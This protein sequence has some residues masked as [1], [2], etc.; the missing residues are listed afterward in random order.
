MEPM[1]FVSWEAL[2]PNQQR[3]LTSAMELQNLASVRM[4]WQAN[5]DRVFNDGVNNRG[6]AYAEALIPAGVELIRMG[7][8]GVVTKDPTFR[9][10]AEDEA[11]VVIQDLNNWWRYRIIP[12]L[13]DPLDRGLAP[14]GLIVDGWWQSKYSLT[15]INQDRLFLSSWTR[16]PQ[17]EPLLG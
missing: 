8:V 9:R 14:D 5:A 12:D 4:D 11:V 6:R 7:I 15:D 1:M 17:M 13:A 16:P 2:S 10:L 3:V